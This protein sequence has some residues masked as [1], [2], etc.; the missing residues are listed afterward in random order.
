MFRELVARIS[1]VTSGADSLKRETCPLEASEY[2]LVLPLGFEE[3]DDLCRI[4]A[5]GLFFNSDW[6]MDGTCSYWFVRDAK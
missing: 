4:L 5:H 1:D 2:T 3:D 6:S